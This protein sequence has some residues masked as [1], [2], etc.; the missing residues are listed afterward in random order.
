MSGTAWYL[1]GLHRRAIL[2]AALA[3]A[4][5]GLGQA[6]AASLD[7]IKKRGYMVAVTEDD[8]RPFE[9]VEDGK[10]TGF[11]NEL[12]VLL[13]K[14]TPIEVRQEIIPWT[15]LLAG[16]STGKYDFALTAALITK[17]RSL[18]LDF[19]MPIADGTHYYVKRKSDDSIKEIKDLNGKI[20]GI[21]AGSGLLQRLP[22][23]ETMLAKTGGKIAKVVEYTS[24][25]EAYQDLALGRTDFVINTVINLQ[26]LVAE[27]PDVFA[28]GQAVS[29]PSYPAWAVKKGNAELL[30]LLND[31]LAEKRKDG[32][33]AALQKKWFGKTFDDLPTS[34]TP[35]F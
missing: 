9:F 2:C 4:V 8:F 6:Q 3:T 20:L 12:L 23:L 35:I 29:G 25:P 10:P 18:S 5:V 34:F 32:T 22:E 27:K 30:A 11:D 31:F 15:G 26:T 16:V 17:E 24:Y 19:T 1:N 33:T 7:E 21:Q 28:L 13:R 14:W